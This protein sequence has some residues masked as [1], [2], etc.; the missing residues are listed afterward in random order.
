MEKIDSEEVSYA[1]EVI[2]ELS[3]G[4]STLQ[5]KQGLVLL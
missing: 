4:L 1:I 3:R 2:G 5:V